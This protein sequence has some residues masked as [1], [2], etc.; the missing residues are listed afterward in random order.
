[1]LVRLYLFLA[2]FIGNSEEGL[3]FLAILLL[4]WF[5]CIV[6]RADALLSDSSHCL[7]LFAH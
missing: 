7:S 2:L 3:N 1:M 6:C 5:D 4:R